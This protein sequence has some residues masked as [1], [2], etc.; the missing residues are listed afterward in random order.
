[1]TE[2]VHMNGFIV[3]FKDKVVYEPPMK[4]VLF[5]KFIFIKYTHYEISK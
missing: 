1:M 2:H 4:L 3:L 5:C